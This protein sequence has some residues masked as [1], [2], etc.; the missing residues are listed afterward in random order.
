MG[1]KYPKGS[2]Q[3]MI[4]ALERRKQEIPQR[5]AAIVTET[6]MEAQEIQR[7]FLDKAT[8]PYGEFRFGNGRGGSA[9]RNDTGTMMD[10]I[11]WEVEKVSRTRIDGRW[12]WLKGILDYFVYQETG[13]G[14]P[15][16]RSLL[17]SYVVVR[18]KFVARMKREFG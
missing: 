6:V 7:E 13:V 9:G 4:R 17:D 1:V 15:E 2:P 5:A 16:A 14:V 3:D 18:E 12:G 10:G 8:T 11:G